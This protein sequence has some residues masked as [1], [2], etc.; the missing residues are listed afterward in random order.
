MTKKRLRSLA[1]ESS[2]RHR[3]L[4]PDKQPVLRRGMRRVQTGHYAVMR[5]MPTRSRRL[6]PVIRTFTPGLG[7]STIL[8]SPT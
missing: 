3:R 8:P 1:S 2:I 6:M 4:L 7:A 5:P